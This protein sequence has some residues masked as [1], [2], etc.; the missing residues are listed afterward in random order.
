MNCKQCTTGFEI[1][2]RDRQFYQK[3]DVPEPTLCPNC[4]AQRRMIFR[5]ERKL[6]QRTCDVTGKK[7][8]SVYTPN[9]SVKVCDKDYWF[10]DK[11]DPIQHGRDFDFDRPFFEQFQEL[12]REIPFPSLR[13]ERSENCDFNNDMSDCS[14][15]YLCAR[16]HK[17]QDML[18]TYRGNTSSSCVDCYQVIQS[19]YLY[20]CVECITCHNS[21]YLYFCSDCSDSAFL[22]DCRN[23][24]NCFMCTNL[25]NKEYYFLNEKLTKEEY[26]KKLS[27]FDFKSYGMMQKAFDLFQN[28]KKKAIQRHLILVNTEE[29]IG[30]NLYEC[31]S[32]HM[33][34]GVKFAQDCGY[35]RDVMR[36]KDSMDA[37]SGG[38]DSELCYETTSVSACH[39]VKFCV[40]V[41]Y[42][43]DISYSFFTKS[44]HDCFGCIGLQHKEYCILNKK[45]S[46]EEYEALVPKI[47]K[48]MKNSPYPSTSSGSSQGSEYGEFFPATLSPFAYNETTAHEYFLMTKEEIENKGWRWHDDEDKLPDVTKV[49]PAE[50]LPDNIK[51]IPEDILNWAIKC[52]ATKR[53]FKITSQELKFYRNHGFPIPHFHP[54]ERHRRR[55][56]FRRLH[57]LFSRN[58][59][60]CQKEIQT[61]Y[62]PEKPEKVY[63]EECYL[64]TVY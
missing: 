34:F 52:K 7:I 32:C 51:D 13:V 6:Y 17:C 58:C 48:H 12:M 26:E 14:N 10:S 28:I 4:R 16:T 49:I 53:P 37:Y 29:S 36:Y 19:E 15:C 35:L 30:D 46:K 42:S 55:L 8:I 44:S 18:Y 33:C 21:K 22:I 31:K 39:N 45:Y 50:K 2:D 11:F 43:N 24:T 61:T 23:C 56:M 40:R 59:S 5:N 20:E 9:A 41:T 63:C 60:K 64:K 27:E 47:I 1:T 62:S 25:R 38:R 54:D 57:K 3:I